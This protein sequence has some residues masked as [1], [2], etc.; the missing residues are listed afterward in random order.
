MTS[1]AA[2]RTSPGFRLD[3]KDQRRYHVKIVQFLEDIITKLTAGANSVTTE[4]SESVS[5][6]SVLLDI[7]VLEIENKS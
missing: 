6:D 3:P 7:K 5:N 4:W 2:L 1:V